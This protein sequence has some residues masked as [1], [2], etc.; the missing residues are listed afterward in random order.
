MIEKLK[1]PDDDM[2]GWIKLLHESD[3]SYEEIDRRLSALNDTY[4]GKVRDVNINKELRKME[5]EIAKR[6]GT[7]FTP[8]EKEAIRK[9]IETRF[10]RR[11][12]KDK[13]ND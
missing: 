12:S 3:M 8:E 13:H 9:G 5:E 6:R 1:I 11:M 4:A 10:Q 2:P 7:G